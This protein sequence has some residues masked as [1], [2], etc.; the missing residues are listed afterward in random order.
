MRKIPGIKNYDAAFIKN[1]S[2]EAL[3]EAIKLVGGHNKFVRQL[4]IYDALLGGWKKNKY[5][6]TPEY[7]VAIE[8]LTQGK[9]SRY[10]LRVDIF[11]EK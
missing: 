1:K 11:Q 2:M 6:V 5:G 10:E 3:K 7:V 4:N 8:Y 9:V